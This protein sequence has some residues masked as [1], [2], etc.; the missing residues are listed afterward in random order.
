MMFWNAEYALGTSKIRRKTSRRSKGASKTASGSAATDLICRQL[1]AAPDE[2]VSAIGQ[3]IFVIARAFVHMSV[4]TKSPRSS[5]AS[6]FANPRAAQ[7]RAIVREYTVEL[8]L[9]FLGGVRPCPSEPERSGSRGHED[10]LATPT[11][12]LA[13]LR[14]RIGAE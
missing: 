9:T 8:G 2:A 6:V 3:R 5:S 7:S 10:P 13:T 14:A 12:P 4:K 11:T 1:I